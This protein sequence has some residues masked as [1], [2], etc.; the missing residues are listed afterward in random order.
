VHGQ[1]GLRSNSAAVGRA[2]EPVLVREV[3]GCTLEPTAITL[4]A[5]SLRG[6]EVSFVS[7]SDAES[8]CPRLWL[9]RE[10]D[11]MVNLKSF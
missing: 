2:T 11:S 5:L 8:R 6:T 4:M 9:S 10:A 7:C 1:C 3:K